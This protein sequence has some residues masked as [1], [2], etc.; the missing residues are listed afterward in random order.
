MRHYVVCVNLLSVSDD[1]Y[2]HHNDSHLNHNDHEVLRFRSI[3]D[4]TS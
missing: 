1:D 4:C 2:C 3:K